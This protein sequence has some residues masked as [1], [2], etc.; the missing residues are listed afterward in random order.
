MK[1]DFQVRAP[2]SEDSRKGPL[3]CGNPQV[4]L[5]V[6]DLTL[7]AAEGFAGAGAVCAQPAQTHALAPWSCQGPWVQTTLKLGP[8]RPRKY[9]DPLFCFY[10]PRQGGFQDPYVYLLVWAPTKRGI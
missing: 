10:G 1:V 5:K 2:F 3:I 7:S 8:Q 9:K 4:T 6:L